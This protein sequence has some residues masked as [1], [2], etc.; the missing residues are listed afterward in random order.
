LTGRALYEECLTICREFEDKSGIVHNL[1]RLGT[2]ALAQDDWGQASTLYAE[3]LALSEDLEHHPNLVH[4][5]NELA[6]TARRQAD[7]VEAEKQFA[8]G[9][10]A[11]Q[12]I[13]HRE[14]IANSLDGLGR[15]AWSRGDHATAHSMQMEA[16]AIRREAR[17]PVS[18]LQSIQSLAI[19]ATAE[20]Q[21]ERAATLFGAVEAFQR[22]V[23]YSYLPTWR[24]ECERSLG[25][26]VTQLGEARFAQALA[27][28]R[29]M[30]LEQA[31]AYALETQ[32]VA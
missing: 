21:A 26:L 24:A 1:E 19:L 22:A 32:A 27:M 5:L 17:H 13:G 9:L 8:K 11:S 23:D 20:Q 30:T 29:A 10:A 28:G 18:L 2:D 16:F 6:E 3:S 12:Q 7:F 4:L 25:A 31:V 15:L 14:D